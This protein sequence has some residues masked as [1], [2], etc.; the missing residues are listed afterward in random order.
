[1]KLRIHNGS[2]RIRLEEDELAALCDEG[3]IEGSLRFGPGPSER[4]LYSLEA[5]EEAE[6]PAAT[7]SRGR[8]AVVLPLAAAAGLLDGSSDQI[9]SMQPAGGTETLQILIEKDCRA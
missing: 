7:F 3:R 4:L 6:E 2:L 8:I 1:M 9:E 5:R